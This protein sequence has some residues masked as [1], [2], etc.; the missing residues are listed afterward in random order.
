MTASEAAPL[1]VGF[2]GTG[3]ITPPMV[4]AL[5][6]RP[7]APG[8][9]IWVTRRSE[10]VSAAL[11][12]EFAAVRVAAP[13]EVVDASDVVFLCVLADVARELLATLSFRSEQK[14]ISVMA[15]I[16][17][18][19]ISERIGPVAELSTTLPV[20]FIESGG[21][22]LPC[23][24]ASP[25]LERL[26]G[27]DNPVIALKEER[28]MA[29]HFAA[30]ALLSPVLE[31]LRTASAWL[32]ARTGEKAGAEAYVAALIGGYL[33]SLPKDGAGRIEAALADLS[34]EGGLNAQLKAALGEA[35]GYDALWA[36]LDAL[37]ERLGA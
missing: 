24:P 5:M 1:R 36:G 19:E 13:Q 23:Y 4:R 16:T 2:L 28:A 10:A 17:L 35:G 21:C 33:A 14:V 22:P 34:T 18:A 7:P 26:F 27:A 31:A 11:A 29:L 12:S 9:E 6:R 3:R 32:A 20:P 25:T 30:S 15:D 8:L 37:A